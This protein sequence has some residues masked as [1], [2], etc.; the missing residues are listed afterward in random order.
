MTMTYT[1]VTII[2]LNYAFAPL[3]STFSG[4]D[5]QK[6]KASA[7]GIIIINI[8]HYLAYTHLTSEYVIVIYTLYTF[9]YIE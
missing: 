6:S 3:G 7:S 1:D 4:S 9:Y 5:G 8:E 2:E